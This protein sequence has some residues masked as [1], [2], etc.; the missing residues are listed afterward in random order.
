MDIESYITFLKN[1]AIRNDLLKNCRYNAMSAFSFLFEYYSIEKFQI[2]YTMEDVETEFTRGLH[3]W[4]IPRHSDIILEKNN[5]SYSNKFLQLKTY[6]ELKEDLKYFDNFANFLI[7]FKNDIICVQLFMDGHAC[8]FIYRKINNIIE[9]YDPVGTTDG[10]KHLINILISIMRNKLPPFK[11]ISSEELHDNIH[12]QIGLQTHANGSN[13][14]VGYCQ[15]WSQLLSNL[16]Y[17]YPYIP[18]NDIIYKHL[19]KC[20]EFDTK[21]DISRHLKLIVRGFYNYVLTKLK[22]DPVLSL[23]DF[24]FTDK[25]KKEIKK[26]GKEYNAFQYNYTKSFFKNLLIKRLGEENNT[27]N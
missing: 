23:F 16:V 6:D 17:R 5:F 13:E 8:L 12:K 25:T 21:R 1:I 10:Y 24:S 3:V 11:Y 7:N 26:L 27:K 18:T 14:D 15:I 20:H 4:R 22:L 9:I 2:P 19:F